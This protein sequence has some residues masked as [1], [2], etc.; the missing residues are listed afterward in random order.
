MRVAVIDLG[1]NTFNLL[2]AEAVDGFS[3]TTLFENK[4]P[5]K[6]GKGGIHNK[7]IQPDAMKRA[8]A[9]L[10]EHVNQ[11]QKFNVHNVYAFGTSALRGAN[12]TK[13]FMR[14]IEER[15]HFHIELI[16]GNR[17]AE[18]IYKG[19][20]QTIELDE[21][22]VL[23]L[24]IGGGSNECIICNSKKIFWKKSYDLGI[25]R[26]LEIF[27]PSDP[28]TNKEIKKVNERFETELQALFSE[29]TSYGV[30]QM[31]GASG[32]FDTLISMI[33]HEKQTYTYDKHSRTIHMDDFNHLYRELLPSSYEERSKMPGL[34]RMR[35]EMIV[36]AIH[37]VKYI[38]DKTDISHLSQSDFSLKEGAVFELLN[39]FH[40]T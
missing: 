36:L 28:M 39:R 27:Q 33:E 11:I 30:S 26:L 34:E 1:T 19:V 24:D 22:P 15:F 7:M 38:I 6:L 21:K 3:Y 10:A 23:I 8:E 25:A 40:G 13:E 2:I 20:R 37:F 29:I 18:L 35:I 9:A 16:D 32:T 14:R 31:I 12:N 5:V 17:E 4:L